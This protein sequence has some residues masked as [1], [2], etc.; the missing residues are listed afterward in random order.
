MSKKDNLELSDNFVMTT[1]D[2][3]S[4]KNGDLNQYLT[5]NQDE[6]RDKLNSKISG[7]TTT[8]SGVRKG[9]RPKLK[10]MI[11]KSPCFTQIRHCF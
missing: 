11:P 1:K 7:R 3:L 4:M 6:I 2:K 9:I 10:K 8:G 5:D